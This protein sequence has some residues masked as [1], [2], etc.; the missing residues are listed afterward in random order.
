MDLTIKGKGGSA[1]REQEQH[2]AITKLLLQARGCSMC[3]SSM[4]SL[5]PIKI[6]MFKKKPLIAFLV[7]QRENRGR[8]VKQLA[9][10]HIQG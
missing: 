9:Q 2:L 6:S 3:F 5:D 7:L 4:N 8:Q 10:D 1:D